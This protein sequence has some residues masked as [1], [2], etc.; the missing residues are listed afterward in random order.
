[1][2]E[3][4]LN[5]LRSALSEAG[6]SREQVAGLVADNFFV[7]RNKNHTAD[8]FNK[9]ISGI[10][11][12]FEATEGE[13]R[14]AVFIH[15]PFIGLIHKRVVQ[16][17][18]DAYGTKDNPVTKDEIRKAV[19]NHPSFAGL[20]HKR[21]IQDIQNV[22]GTEEYPVSKDKVRQ[23]VL[24][25]PR[26]AGLNHERVLKDFQDSHGRFF[27]LKK[28]EVVDFILSNPFVASYS[29]KRH[30]AML[31]I[32]SMPSVARMAEYRGKNV[33]KQYLWNWLK[34]NPRLF[35]GSPYVHLRYPDGKIEKVPVE[36]AL[37]ELRSR[38]ARVHE[39]PTFLRLY[40]KKALSSPRH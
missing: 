40:R 2:T 4:N 23:V 15:P 26:F 10:A 6:F 5:A 18:Q 36:K 8:Y 11:K 14:K 32:L 28:S 31:D 20:D 12:E 38:K 37:T 24:L 29:A 13:I 27:N 22:Y 16:D 21:V 34:S 30:N 35:F 1:M 3:N 17:I 19:F 33:S 9:K 7:S 25:S 39:K